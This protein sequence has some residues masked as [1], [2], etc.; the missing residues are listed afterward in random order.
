M[1]DHSESGFEAA[2]IEVLTHKGW[3]SAVLQYPTEAQLLRNWA[4][5]LFENNRGIDRL[6]DAPLTE[7]EMQQIV[8]QIIALGTPLKLNGS[9]A[10]STT[11]DRYSG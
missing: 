8:E 5:I 4:A 6:N 3:E 7:G 11:F 2:L 10:L 1:T 9:G